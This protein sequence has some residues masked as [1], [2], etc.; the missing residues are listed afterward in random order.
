VLVL[1]L[2]II[3]LAI[4]L[5]PVPLTAFILVLSSKQ[6]ARKGAWFVLGWLLSLVAV[7]II[8]LLATGNSPPKPSTGPS[9]AALAVKIAIGVVLLLIALR[10]RR[11]IGKPKK[12]KKTPRWQSGIDNMSPLYAMG[13][14]LFVQPWGLIAAG[15]ANIVNAKLASWADYLGL[16]FFCLVATGTYLAMEIYAV[17]RPERTQAF[18]SRVR[19]WIDSHTD[20]IIVWV[21]L[22]LGLWLIGD[23]IYI[24]VS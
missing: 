8:T 1:E 18:L 2:L 9:L 7:I 19:I 13:L 22:I 20:V 16:I 5:E 21:S 11:R 14:A 15:V 6:G 17:A 10:Q 23:S 3:G 24:L 12:A 4:T